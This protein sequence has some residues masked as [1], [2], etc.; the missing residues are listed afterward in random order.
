MASTT[1]KD[2]VEHMN[3]NNDK[4]KYRSRSQDVLTETETRSLDMINPKRIEKNLELCSSS[5]PSSSAIKIIEILKD[6][7]NET[8]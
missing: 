1:T 2:T 6:G 4:K 8:R 7:D 5:S 3:K